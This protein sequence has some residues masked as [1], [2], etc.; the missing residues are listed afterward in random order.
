MQFNQ[1]QNTDKEGKPPSFFNSKGIKDKFFI[2]FILNLF[3][4]LRLFKKIIVFLTKQLKKA[5]VLI[6]FAGHNLIKILCL[7]FYKIYLLFKKQIQKTLGLKDFSLLKG[8]SLFYISFFV[9]ILLVA[10]DNLKVK[11]MDTGM[12]RQN[13][14]LYHLLNEQEEEFITETD[15]LV[16]NSSFDQYLS[17][18]QPFLETESEDQKEETIVVQEG[19]VLVKPN[20]SVTIETPQIRTKPIQYIVKAGDVISGIAK[21][22]NVS[23]NTILWENNLKNYS[24]IKPGDELIILPL[25]GVVH[26]VAKG[27]SLGTIAK[28]YKVAVEEILKMNEL[29]NDNIKINQKI[30]IPGGS[31]YFPSIFSKK[32]YAFLPNKFISS[33]EW[34]KFIWPTSSHKINQ[35]YHSGH[36]GID[37]HGINYS[38]PIYASADGIIKQT[39]YSNRGYGRYIIISHKNNINTLYGHMSKLFVEREQAVKKG[40]V[41]GLLGTTGH[42]TGPHLHFEIRINGQKVNP[43]KYIR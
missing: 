36:K 1:F 7:Y 43:L 4:L 13:T 11:A 31:K 27:E 19:T 3:S 28:K 29:V 35:Y 6:S 17:N 33:K 41:I 30:I 21:R 8:Y 22:F 20:I 23:V 2:F 18:N 40:Q 37:I 15:I 32:Q 12:I 24:I 14:I 34:G 16:I 5:I 25:T 42:S 38:S 9:I 10:F 26:K 39:I